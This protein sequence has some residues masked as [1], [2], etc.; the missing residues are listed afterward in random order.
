M[1]KS[2]LSMTLLVALVLLTAGASRA[3][4]WLSTLQPL[5][6]AT[7]ASDCTPKTCGERS[8]GVIDRGCGLGT[9]NCGPCADDEVCR[10]NTCRRI[11]PPPHCPCGGHWPNACQ[12]CPESSSK[13]ARSSVRNEDCP[14]GVS[15]GACRPCPPPDD[16]C[17]CGPRKGPCRMCDRSELAAMA[18]VCSAKGKNCGLIDNGHGRKADCG[19]C[20]GAETCGGGGV[21]NVCGQPQKK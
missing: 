2:F 17:P 9:V 19:T 12:V 20:K 16:G 10:N 21:P 4:E 6:L 1:K 7:G 18:S 8:C 13:P 5:C 15:R 3:S 14:C 11:I